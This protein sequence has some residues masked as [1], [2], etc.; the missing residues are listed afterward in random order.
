MASVLEQH[1]APS[2]LFM[3]LISIFYWFTGVGEGRVQQSSPR[4]EQHVLND[5]TGL[6]G[7]QGV[8]EKK[9]R[10]NGGYEQ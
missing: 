1:R 5:V 4:L 8:V 2:P 9:S 10:T 7:L 3:G 6:R